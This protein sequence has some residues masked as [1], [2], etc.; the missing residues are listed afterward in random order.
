[1]VIHDIYCDE[2]GKHSDHPVVTFSGVCVAQPKLQQFDDALKE[3]LRRYELRSL[4]MARVSRLSEKHGSL[5]PRGQSAEERMNA[6]IPFADCI[7]DKLELGLLQAWDVEGFNS[8]SK[9]AKHGFG[10]PNDP[11]FIAFTRGLLEAVDYV[12]EDHRLSLICDHDIETAWDS[13]RHYKGVR[14]AHEKVRKKTVAITFADDEYFPALQAAD[15]V[16]FL[17]RLEAKSRFY[18]DRYDFRRL[19]DYV[20]KEKGPNRM[21]WKTMFADKKM[22]KELGTAQENRLKL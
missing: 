5:M 22:I 10:S 17:S 18:G 7:N 16:A 14:N 12:H 4:H 1:M 9:S 19:F 3:L 6:L 13:Y 21:A 11:Y 20:T 8:L 2:S 15:M